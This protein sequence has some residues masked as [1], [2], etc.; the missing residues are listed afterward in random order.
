MK[1]SVVISGNSLH[2]DKISNSAAEV[3]LERVCPC[4]A[5]D[6]R[7]TWQPNCLL[8]SLLL[9]GLAQ[10][11]WGEWKGSHWCQWAGD[12]FLMSVLW[13]AREQ[14]APLCCLCLGNFNCGSGE[15]QHLYLKDRKGNVK[16]GL[17]SAARQEKLPVSENNEETG[18]CVWCVFKRMF[19]ELLA[20]LC[21]SV[22]LILVNVSSGHVCPSSPAPPQFSSSLASSFCWTQLPSSPLPRAGSNHHPSQPHTPFLLWKPSPAFSVL[23]GF[24]RMQGNFPLSVSH[25]NCPHINYLQDQPE[26]A[27]HPWWYREQMPRGLARASCHRQLQLLQFSLRTGEPV[28]PAAWSLK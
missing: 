16:K 9:L 1:T 7:K 26:H 3:T 25:R 17:R 13:R 18:R 23:R 28:Y 12:Q 6:E 14:R 8:S 19:K 22:V 11:S 24:L 20:L 21:V 15:K 10:T 4:K 27:A 2:R 5:L